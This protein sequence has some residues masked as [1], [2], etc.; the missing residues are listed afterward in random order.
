MT[1]SRPAVAELRRLAALAGPILVVQ[2]SYTGMSATNVIIAGQL[3]ATDLAGVAVGAGVWIPIYLTLCGLLYALAPLVAYRQGSGAT[4]QIRPLLQ[5]G[6]CCGLALAA[7][8]M[9]L[10]WNIEPLL[11]WMGSPEPVR[12]VAVDYLRALCAGIPAMMLFQLLRNL[13][14]GLGL[15]RLAMRVGTVAFALNIPLAWCLVKGGAG[16]PA[17]GGAGCGIAT[18]LL[19]WVMFALLWLLS[20]R[21]A[22]IAPHLRGTVRLDGA[23][24]RE[25][26]Q[27]GLP[28]GVGLFLESGLFALVALLLAPLGAVAVAAHQVALNIAATLFML[29][30]SLALALTV[31]LGHHLG[32]SAHPAAHR[33]LRV[34]LAMAAVIATGNTLLILLLGEPLVALHS[35][36]AA[37]RALALRLLCYA[38][39][40]QLSDCMQMT[41]LGA[42]RALGQTRATMWIAFFVYWGVT[43]PLGYSL[44]IADWLGP[45]RGAEGLWI[46]LTLGITLAAV[47]LGWR[48]RQ[49]SL[50][51]NTRAQTWKGPPRTLS[52]PSGSS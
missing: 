38:A 40:F 6:L 46:G 21:D 52:D 19:F 10:L 8:G 47:L 23:L 17:L 3:S 7:L 28:I 1:P 50:F 37:V 5:V 27:L 12:R 36:D 33:T 22:R 2:M 35:G 24:L 32:A 9:L 39:L 30:L 14:E 45:P 13:N 34:A 15:P 26:L 18:A 31:R 25:F 11:R 4:A 41:L 16:L 20:R 51:D 42:L 49:S 44:G 43:L 29:P 48:L